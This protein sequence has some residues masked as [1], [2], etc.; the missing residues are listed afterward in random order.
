MWRLIVKEN[1]WK[2]F[3]VLLFLGLLSASPLSAQS[4]V[5]YVDAVSGDDTNNCV[6]ARNPSTPLRTIGMA[7]NQC[8]VNGDTV[9]VKPG[10]Y[11]ETVDLRRE[12]VTL[13]AEPRRGATI[14][15]PAGQGVLVDSLVGI[16][17]EGFIV[18]G[19]TT[20]ISFIR[21][22]NGTVRDNVV[23]SNTVHGINFSDSAAGLIEK[24]IVHTNNQM[25]IRYL[26]GAN[27]VVRNN[28]VYNNDDWG[29]SLEM[30]PA[31]FSSGNVIESNTVDRNVHGVRLLDGG[32]SILNNI[33][34]SNGST[35][36]KLSLSLAQVQE[37]Y[38][39]VAGHTTDFD[40]QGT[41]RPG[42]H[43]ISVDPLYVGPGGTEDSYFLSQRAAGQQVDSPCL[44]RGSG[45]AAGSQTDGST[46]TDNFPDEGILDL[47]FHYPI[48][49]STLQV[50]SI[51]S[52]STAIAKSGG[53][54]K[55]SYTISGQFRLG[56]DSNGI[57]PVAERTRV[58]VDT[59]SETLPL[60]SCGRP[61][62][63]TYNCGAPS[64]GITSLKIKFTSS[65]SGTF[66]LIVKLVPTPSNPLPPNVRLRLFIGD[67][68]GVA[69][70]LYVRGNLLAP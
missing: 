64:P 68:I 19:G 51:T 4:L 14:R 24:N 37:D 25:G 30:D 36:L 12:N 11:N 34:T 33:I 60:G 10:V 1:A 7:I 9:I 21:S 47:G 5:F 48:F 23:Y 29:I 28:L 44:D 57:N 54:L 27:G 18:E 63:G 61:S 6:E 40:Y 43:T 32:G 20:G 39:N 62:A 3:F 31:A 17:V 45:P 56:A 50:F 26:R 65:T 66:D 67:D 46:A 13:R 41:D 69:E 35:G 58:E 22:D 8:I 53:V 15:P 55:T 2:T 52:V 59:Y 38:N 49:R 16:T 70:K 42:L